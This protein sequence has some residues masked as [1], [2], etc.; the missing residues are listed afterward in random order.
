MNARDPTKPRKPWAR[1]PVR[2]VLL[3]ST[4]ALA[5]AGC[6]DAP[7]PDDTPVAL[8][9]PHY[10][11]FE[12]CVEDWQDPRLCESGDS[13]ELPADA[14]FDET[15]ADRGGPAPGAGGGGA[16]G[17]WWGPYYSRSGAAYLYDGRI[18]RLASL[19]ARAVGHLVRTASLG[20]VY[21]SPTGR[22]ATTPPHPDGAS[23]A[24]VAASR[25][26]S[27][28]GFGSGRLGSFSGGG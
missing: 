21:R 17:G 5:L 27:R 13:V 8:E 25:A 26:V 18:V 28:G 7:G 24:K 19:P 12:D 22:Y 11:W 9:R 14:S 10:A 20:Q 1:G 2:L 16:R 15:G 3:G 6:D 4:T 23:P